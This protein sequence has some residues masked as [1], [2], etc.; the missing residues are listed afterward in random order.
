MPS[1]WTITLHSI[2]S[3][4]AL[5]SGVYVFIEKKVLIG[6]RLVPGEVYEMPFPVNFIMASSLIL[7]SMFL[8]M[9]LSENKTIKKISEWVLILAVCLFFVC[10][11]I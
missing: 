5:S 3:L 9:T 6:G 8:M 7:L 10:A 2:L 11:F 1:F 4:A